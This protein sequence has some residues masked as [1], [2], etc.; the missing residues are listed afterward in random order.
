MYM[1]FV[2]IYYLDVCKNIYILGI[3]RGQSVVKVRSTGFGAAQTKRGF[4]LY[5]VQ[6]DRVLAAQTLREGPTNSRLAVLRC[7]ERV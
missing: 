6:A 1:V 5:I 3:F 2:H 4:A 7:R